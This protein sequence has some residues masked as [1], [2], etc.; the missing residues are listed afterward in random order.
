[1]R[2]RRH[3]AMPGEMLAHRRHATFFKAECQGLCQLLNRLDVA[4]KS[5][6][7]NNLTFTVIDIQYRRKTEIHAV[8]T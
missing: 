4:M 1:M 6:V 2:I 8:G 3:K 7:A 5:A